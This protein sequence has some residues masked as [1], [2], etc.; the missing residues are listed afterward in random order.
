MTPDDRLK[1]ELELL[2]DVAPAG[3]P[4]RLP[5]SSGRRSLRTPTFASALLLALL[6]VVIAV[7][8]WF[9]VRQLGPNPHGS[10][11]EPIGTTTA[12]PSD[13]ATACPSSSPPQES[14]A[15]AGPSGAW[16]IE[17]LPAV[18]GVT[19]ASFEGITWFEGLGWMAYGM[20]ADGLAGIWVSSDEASWAL[21]DS[22]VPA[23]GDGYRVVDVVRGV[24]CGQWRYVAAVLP[25]RRDRDEVWGGTLD[26]SLLLVSDDAR[27]WRIAGDTPTT[28]TELKGL[29][30]ASTGFAVVG[31]RLRGPASSGPRSDGVVWWSSD[32]EAWTETTPD[33]MRLSQ[34]LGV[35]TLGGE[36]IAT[37]F[38]DETGAPKEAWTSGDGLSWTANEIRPAENEGS[39][40]SVAR[41]N[42]GLIAVIGLG[43]DGTFAAL[44]G[45]GRTWSTEPL[46]TQWADP[47]GVAI[48]EGSIVAVGFI[49][50][51]DGTPDV[52]LWFRDAQVRTWR[53]V[54]W[55]D[56]VPDEREDRIAVSAFIDVATDGLSAAIL[57][58]DGTVIITDQL[59]P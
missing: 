22:P 19:A 4:P 48:S 33:S 52:Y 37:G 25:M 11:P 7:P 44:S 12:S 56:Y 20:D 29:A 55:R 50:P 40:Y 53:S 10:S 35:E 46:P 8:T 59:F 18:G 57:E 41:A 5:T 32:G 51:G 16:R 9:V 58:D 36:F 42:E 31:T 30:A 13:V 38:K 47:T 54:A 6:V 24:V 28:P 27:T 43:H 26:R 1:T 17:A 3:A 39:V 34:P 21:A 15:P 45:D 23:P 14:P 2:E 49:Q